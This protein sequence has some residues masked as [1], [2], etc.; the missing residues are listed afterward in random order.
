MKRSEINDLL[1][2]AEACFRA[3]HWA[4]PPRPRWDVTDFG[5]GDHRRYGLVLVNLT[6]QVE[7]CEIYALEAG[8][9]A[10]VFEDER[11]ADLWLR[12]PERP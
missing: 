11:Q 5:L 12:H 4:L 6:E 2:A 3:H 9:D 1:R 7:Y 8:I 10:Q